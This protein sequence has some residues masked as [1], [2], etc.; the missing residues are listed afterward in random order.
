VYLLD[1]LHQ[2]LPE[3]DLLQQ[4]MPLQ[5][6]RNLLQIHQQHLPILPP[7]LRLLPKLLVMHQMLPELLPQ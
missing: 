6:P 7:K 3:L 4:L 5:L 1:P 2:M